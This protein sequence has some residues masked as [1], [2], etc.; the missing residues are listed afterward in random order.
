MRSSPEADAGSARTS[1]ASSR[2]TAGRSSSPRGRATDRGGRGRDRRP[3]DRLGRVRPRRGRA[4]P[5]AETGEPSSCSWPTPASAVRSGATWEVDPAEWW[6]VQ[7]INVLG[8][9]LCCRAVI[10]G[11]LERG[12]GRIVITGSGAAYLPGSSEH[13]LL[14]SKAAVCRYGETLANELR[15]RIPVFVFSPGLVKTAMTEPLGRRPALDAAGACAAARARPRLGPGGRARRAVHPRRARRHRGSD[16]PRGRDRGERPERDSPTALTARLC[17]RLIVENLC[18]SHSLRSTRRS[19]TS[20]GTA[21][22]SSRGSTRRRRQAQTSSS[23]PSSRSPA[24]R[25]KISCS[26]RA[27][28]RRRSARLRRSHARRA[29]SSPSSARRTSTATST[30]CAPSARAAR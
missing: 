3:C 21:S 24:I 6:H 22:G 19:A 26:A 14:T 27:S 7:E 2:R 11:M 29:A 23:S 20:T 5:C 10:P 9:H 1:P 16:R 28:S 30:T 25:R 4:R 15:G 18:D 13:R 12:S 17:F 8:V